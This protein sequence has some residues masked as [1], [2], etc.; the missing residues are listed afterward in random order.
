MN[1]IVLL[2][3][4]ALL[5]LAG[6]LFIRAASFSRVRAVGTLGQIGSYGYLTPGIPDGPARTSILGALATKLGAIAAPRFG[7]E[8]E[9]RMRELL[10]SAGFYSLE[11]RRFLGYRVLIA[12]A[13][14]I[15]RI[16]LAIVGGSAG[17]FFYLTFPLIV[18][19]G[20]Y[21]PL[22]Y[23]KMRARKRLKEIDAE[24]PELIDLLVVTVEA[25]LGFVG[26]LKLSAERLGGPLGEE[27]RLTL[28]EQAMGLSSSEA[29]RNMQGRTDTP[30]MQ[31]FVRSVLQG[32]TLG[33]PT[34]EIMRS[35]AGEMRKR[36]RALAEEKA[37]KA[38]IKIL[39]PL[40]FLIF[41]AM[42]IVI[43]APAVYDFLHTFSAA[44]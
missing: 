15:F 29:L 32:E 33:V 5:G 36:R 44:R 37:Q 12:V 28:Q 24:L 38:P 40:V 26:A 41:P 25:G 20:W 4:L 17:V 6:I 19:G 23:V 35:L 21:L 43:L 22:R 39:F 8:R 14:P 27:I 1:I 42:F 7:L 10:Q 9:A 2:I 11:P 31:S 18:L 13:L 16:W 34:A 3:G 30:G